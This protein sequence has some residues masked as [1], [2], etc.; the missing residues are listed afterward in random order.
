MHTPRI[1]NVL[2]TG[3]AGYIG[4]ERVRVLRRERRERGDVAPTDAL[5]AAGR[6]ARSARGD[7]LGTARGD[8]L[9]TPPRTHGAAPR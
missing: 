1:V 5:C 4:S 7:A 9:G 3:A 8:A 2:V 6:G